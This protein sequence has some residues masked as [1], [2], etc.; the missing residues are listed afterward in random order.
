MK[1]M[2]Q[3]YTYI[4]ILSI[5]FAGCAR[6]AKQWFVVEKLDNKTYVISEP[7]SSQGNS[8]FLLL[9][10]REAILFDSGTGE[11]EGKGIARIT[12]TITNL[13]LTLLLSHFH[14]DHIGNTEEFSR[15]GI[16][17]LD[18]FRSRIARDSILNLSCK[19]VLSE[20]TKSLKV[21]KCFPV[22]EEI[23]LGNRRITI[24]HTPGHS[25]ESISIVDRENKYVFMGDLAYNGLLLVND[26]R[27]YVNSINCLLNRSDSTYRFFG[28]HGKSEVGF[29]HLQRI[30]DALECYQNPEWKPESVKQINFFGVVK[31]LITVDGV[32]F[33]VGY[34]DVFTNDC[35]KET[36]S[37][38]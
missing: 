11:N 31:D 29:A 6:K 25:R 12:D 4:L 9:G 23:D 28:S 33:I 38:E 10:D 1:R 24:L 20:N 7:N 17:E 36:G 8:C 35:E 16:P 3:I 21:S 27:K 15:I 13:P 30:G 2:K 19:E 18:C 5:C 34:R 22:G 14:F 37:N 26:C 32:S